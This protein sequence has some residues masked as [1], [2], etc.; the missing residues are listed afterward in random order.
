MAYYILYLKMAYTAEQK[1]ELFTLVFLFVK[2]IQVVEN[3]TAV[4]LHSEYS[5]NSMTSYIPT[6]FCN[7]FHCQIITSS[8]R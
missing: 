7:M 1:I 8:A 5:R 3:K 2:F 6:Q 4:Q